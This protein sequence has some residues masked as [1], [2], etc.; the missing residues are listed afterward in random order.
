MDNKFDVLQNQMD[1]SVVKA[2]L[3]K[4]NDYLS[5]QL[6]MDF[7]Y[8]SIDENKLVLSGCTDQTWREDSIE[9]IFEFPQ[10]ISTVFSWT[11]NEKKP[12][13]ILATPEEL[14]KSTKLISENGCHIFA[15]NDNQSEEYKIFIS[16]RGIR[17][18][19]LKPLKE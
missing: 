14:K 6:W 2:E 12:F 13:I 8:G 10:L 5:K 3:V 7:D 11:M 19:I 1:L 4:I 18:N 16:A 9:I 17:C 15:L